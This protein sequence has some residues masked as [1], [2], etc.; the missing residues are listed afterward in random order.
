[1][2]IENVASVARLAL[3]RKGQGPCRKGA[4]R[5]APKGRGPSPASPTESGEGR[6]PLAS[7]ARPAVLGQHLDVGPKKK[8][9]A[10]ARTGH[11][12]S[13]GHHRSRHRL[14]LLLSSS[15]RQLRPLS[16]GLRAGGSS[17]NSGGPPLP[18]KAPAGCLPSRNTCREPSR[19]FAPS[20]T[21]L[22]T[23]YGAT[24]YVPRR[25]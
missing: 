15:S 18:K 20:R 12:A 16:R 22:P 2:V 13:G 14:E 23:L 1:M 6:A 4:A 9:A 8:P 25:G 21:R 3:A 5:G 10:L 24:L 7:R 19:A 11:L 17:G